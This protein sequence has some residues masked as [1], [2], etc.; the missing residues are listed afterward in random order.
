MDARLVEGRVEALGSCG[1][2]LQR[3]IP[4]RRVVEARGDAKRRGRAVVGEHDV[5]ASRA[6]GAVE[7]QVD[8]GNVHPLKLANLDVRRVAAA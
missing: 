2:R 6:A 3:P 7:H 4:V 5:G 8:V 1:A